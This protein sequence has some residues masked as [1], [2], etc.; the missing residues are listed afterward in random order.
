LADWSAEIQQQELDVLSP[1]AA[2]GFLLE[3]TEDRRRR[4]PEDEADAPAL[5]RELEGL[6]LLLEQAGAFCATKRSSFRGISNDGEIT[7][8]WCVSGLMRD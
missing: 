5:A 7:T 4:L 1:E 3:R 8:S 6:A 2:T